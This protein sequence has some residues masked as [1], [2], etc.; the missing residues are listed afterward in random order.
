MGLWPGG[1]FCWILYLPETAP[2][3][4]SGFPLLMVAV[5]FLV[6]QFMVGRKDVNFLKPQC[7]VVMICHLYSRDKIKNM[8]KLPVT[9]ALQAP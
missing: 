4:L 9:T 2:Q 5:Y 1:G 6:S 8:G 7:S 3:D